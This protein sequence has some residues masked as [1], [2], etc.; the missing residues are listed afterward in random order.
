MITT[1]VFMDD[2]TINGKAH[3]QQFFLGWNV[4]RMLK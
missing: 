3:M 4:S 2:S 1:P